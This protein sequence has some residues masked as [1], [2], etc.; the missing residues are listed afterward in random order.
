MNKNYTEIF[1]RY[2]IED[3]EKEIS[4]HLLNIKSYKYLLNEK[5]ELLNNKKKELLNNKKK[6]K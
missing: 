6:D 2:E 1:L 4:Q 3:I 5:K